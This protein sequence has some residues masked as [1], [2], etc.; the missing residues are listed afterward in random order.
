M[1]P[2]MQLRY[3]HDDHTRELR[4]VRKT[5]S[6]EVPC[7]QVF[8]VV[9]RVWFLNELHYHHAL[10]LADDYESFAEGIAGEVQFIMDHQ[11]AC[12]KID[13]SL[14]FVRNLMMQRQDIKDAAIEMD[15]TT[16]IRKGIAKRNDEMFMA[17]GLVGD[18]ELSLIKVVAVDA[19][20]AIEC[21]SMECLHQNRDK[22]TPVEICQA[23]P[24]TS[25]CYALFDVAAAR[26]K[27][28][29]DSNPINTYL[30]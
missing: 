26:I 2:P 1:N 20:K 27:A 21:A 10:I 7:E 22:F 28:L 14:V 24:V 13:V 23:H 6:V 3:R 5:R 29:L 17:L 25:E 11:F 8:F 30:Q 18:K 16:D 15:I 4:D 19:L 12:Y 9:F